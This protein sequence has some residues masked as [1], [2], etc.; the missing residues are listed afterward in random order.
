[1]KHLIISIAIALFGLQSANAQLDLKSMLGSLVSS[2]KIN[3][4]KISGS[5][6]YSSPAVTFKSDNILKKAGGAAA[7]STVE[8]KLAPYYSKAGFTKMT[9]VIEPDSTFS[10]KLN[11][12]TLKGTIAPV[13]DEN[14]QANFVF[15]FKV[16]GKL[17]IG[18]MDAYVTMSGSNTMSL[19]FD[20]TKLVAIIEKAGTVTNN[21]TIKGVTKL[22]ESYDGICAGFKLKK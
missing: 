14:S 4:D 1:M 21:S 3:V 2:D 13:T 10:M 16:G 5:W 7:A 18:K 12:T 22:L 8:A 20:V 15:N 11:R 9:L 6:S 19:T 17:P